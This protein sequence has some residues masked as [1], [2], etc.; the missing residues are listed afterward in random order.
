M[1]LASQMG[2]LLM[3]NDGSRRQPPH[4][5]INRRTR[6]LMRFGAYFFYPVH[7]HGY[8]RIPLAAIS[9]WNRIQRAAYR[10]VVS[11]NCYNHGTYTLWLCNIRRIVFLNVIMW[12]FQWKY[13]SFSAECLNIGLI[14]I[15]LLDKK[16]GNLWVVDG[17]FYCNYFFSR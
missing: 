7:F 11:L 10:R 4:S 2:L 1:L 8:Q 3:R 15:K 5:I 9:K 17:C 14:L 12:K 13:W 16:F 6:C